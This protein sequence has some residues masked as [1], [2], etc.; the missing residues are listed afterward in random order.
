VALEDRIA[1]LGPTGC[2]PEIVADLDSLIEHESK[3]FVRLR[4]N[5][6]LHRSD[7]TQGRGLVALFDA[8]PQDAV[9]RVAPEPRATPSRIER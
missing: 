4:D 3:R 7:R 6:R 1:A 2:W 5:L 8:S 9:A